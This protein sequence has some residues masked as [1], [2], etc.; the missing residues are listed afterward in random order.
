MNARESGTTNINIELIIVM[1]LGCVYAVT[2]QYVIL[3]TRIESQHYIMS[4]I[5]SANYTAAA[6]SKPK[7]IRYGHW[8]LKYGEKKSFVFSCHQIPRV[9][10]KYYTIKYLNI[11][12][13]IFTVTDN[14]G[15]Y[16]V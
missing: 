2:S 16:P 5:D 8:I 1:R 11:F 12:I 6:H 13:C 4:F 15:Q 9:R 10:L 3:S 7:F 14:H